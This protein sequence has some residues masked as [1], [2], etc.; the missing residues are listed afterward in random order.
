MCKQR[1]PRLY[2]PSRTGL[3]S[4]LLPAEPAFLLR[5]PQPATAS[6]HRPNRRRN[7]RIKAYE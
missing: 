7:E 6:L 2:V 3:A 5:I 4:F 1:E